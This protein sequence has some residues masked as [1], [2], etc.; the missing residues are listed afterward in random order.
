MNFQSLSSEQGRD[1]EDVVLAALKFYGWKQSERHVRLDGVEIDIVALSPMGETWWIECKGSHRGERP[2]CLR[3]DTVKKAV[4]VAYHLLHGDVERHPYML[5]TSHMPRL[6]SKSM[7]MLQRAQ[8][9]GA[10]RRV[11]TIE[12]CLTL[13]TVNGA[14]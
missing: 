12:Q 10:F 3:E 13:I 5:V 6:G 4:G 9:C 1:W 8:D 2:G 14:T 11:G 7:A